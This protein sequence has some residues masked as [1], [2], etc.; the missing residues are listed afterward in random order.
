MIVPLARS[1]AKRL[2]AFPRLQN[3]DLNQADKVGS[4]YDT[5]FV[6]PLIDRP[7]IIARGMVVRS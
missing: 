4:L 1:G 6:A 2:R 7:G 3:S 5:R